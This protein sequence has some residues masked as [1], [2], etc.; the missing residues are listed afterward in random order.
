[1]FCGYVCLK[2]VYYDFVYG[3]VV[4]KFAKKV[5]LNRAFFVFERVV[6]IKFVV[7]ICIIF[8]GVL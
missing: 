5:D 7:L 2:F 3:Y 8:F 6:A 1:M 4:M